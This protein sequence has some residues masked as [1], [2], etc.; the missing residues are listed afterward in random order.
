[1]KAN[2]GVTSASIG[3]LRRHIF[4]WCCD[5]RDM[6]VEIGDYKVRDAWAKHSAMITP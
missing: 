3:A 1:M 4:R 6:D 5:V 2:A